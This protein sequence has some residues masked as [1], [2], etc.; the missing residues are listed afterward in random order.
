MHIK[1]LTK[2]ICGSY[3]VASNKSLKSFLLT[4]NPKRTPK[5]D[6][7]SEIQRLNKVLYLTTINLLYPILL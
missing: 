3:E 5:N 7:T 6:E 1:I 2:L 4:S